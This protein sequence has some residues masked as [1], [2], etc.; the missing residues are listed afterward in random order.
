MKRPILYFLLLSTLLACNDRTREREDPAPG[1]PIVFQ[2]V[3]ADESDVEVAR[4]YSFDIHVDGTFDYEENFYYSFNEGF[5]LTFPFYKASY[6]AGSM[7]VVNPRIH[8]SLMCR[9]NKC[10]SSTMMMSG[11][12]YRCDVKH[13]RPS[14]AWKFITTA[15]R[16]GYELIMNELPGEIKMAG[17]TESLSTTSDNVIEFEYNGA[18]SILPGLLAIPKSN[19]NGIPPGLIS[20]Q[21]HFPVTSKNNR[22]IV[23]GGMI[24]QASVNSTD[25]AFINLIS[26][27]RVF[28][29]VEGKKIAINYRKNHLYPTLIN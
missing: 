4:E 11:A 1:K 25:T 16:N 28:K 21:M 19:L 26:I 24:E 12:W 3:D 23:P 10:D 14:F 13:T 15:T 6:E 8:H 22:F 17:A 5:N 7:P 29:I 2:Q 20:R 18:D 27:K 9:S